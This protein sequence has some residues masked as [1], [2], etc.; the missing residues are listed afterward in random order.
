MTLN[1]DTSDR[2]YLPFLVTVS[3]VLIA[4][5][6]VRYLH[7]MSGGLWLFHAGWVTLSIV[8]LRWLYDTRALFA[9]H[10][11]LGRA[12]IYLFSLAIGMFLFSGILEFGYD[13][14][15][16]QFG[17]NGKIDDHVTPPQT[18]PSQSTQTALSISGLLHVGKVP[19]TVVEPPKTVQVRPGHDFKLS[20]KVYNPSTIPVQFRALVSVVPATSATLIKALKHRYP[21]TTVSPQTSSVVTLPLHLTHHIPKH[22]PPLMIGFALFQMH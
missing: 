8:S 22:T 7:Q 20:F 17:V 1:K 2:S 14:A 16:R 12:G 9:R 6:G 5:G 13:Q 4:L 10:P 19:V 21:S 11:R 15:T 18:A 3:L